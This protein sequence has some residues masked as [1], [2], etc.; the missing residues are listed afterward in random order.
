LT[1]SVHRRLPAFPTRRSSDLPLMETF[2]RNTARE[3]RNGGYRTTT[4]FGL[5]VNKED[6]RR[7][8]P[9]HDL[10]LWEGHYKTLVDHYGL[11][12]WSRSEEHTSELQSLAY[13]VCRLL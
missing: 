6:V 3:L 4:L 12:S 8:L 7:L 11:P 9:E 13:L 10:F 1:Y 5:E 2:S